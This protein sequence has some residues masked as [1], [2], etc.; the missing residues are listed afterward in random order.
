MQVGS[1]GQ[2]N[3]KYS[4]E[5]TKHGLIKFIIQDEQL[6]I[7]SNFFFATCMQTYINP[8]FKSHSKNTTKN[9]IHLFKIRLF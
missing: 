4:V 3:W 5:E 7:F 6:F 2:I 9:I 1:N 8:Q